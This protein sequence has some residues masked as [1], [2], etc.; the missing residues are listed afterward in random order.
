MM[1]APKARFARFLLASGSF[2]V[3]GAAACAPRGAQPEGPTATG[4]SQA[5]ASAPAPSGVYGPP[6][7]ADLAKLTRLQREVTQHAGTEPPFQ[8]AY[9]DNH[10]VGLYVDVVTGEPLFSSRDKFE[11]GTGWPSFTR[12]IEA[13]RVLTAVDASH[14]M[15]RTEVR[16]SGGRS[17]LG[18]VFEDGPAP[19]G[20]RYC[21]NSASLRFVPFAELEAAGYGAYRARFLATNGTPPPAAKNNACTLPAPGQKAGCSSTL[22]VASFAGPCVA[23]TRDRLDHTKGVL[24]TSLGTE[25][26]GGVPVVKVVFDP[27]ETRYEAIVDAFLADGDVP[28]GSAV[29]AADAEQEGKARASIGRSKLA[30]DVRRSTAFHVPTNVAEGGSTMASAKCAPAR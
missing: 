29:L 10:A 6:T 27:R 3:L 13:G 2:V 11:S 8:N 12:P 18:H 17:H 9:W 30:V 5:P 20:L 1:A 28:A 14:G 19:T 15:T 22:A 7:E 23:S 16:S 21:I 24:D 4:P 26:A 25:G